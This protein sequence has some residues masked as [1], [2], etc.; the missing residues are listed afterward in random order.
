M[1]ARGASPTELGTATADLSLFDWNLA[2]ECE[3][4]SKLT[5][6]GERNL[7]AVNSSRQATE[8]KYFFALG[9][10]P[11]L[12]IP[13]CPDGLRRQLAS[14]RT[15]LLAR[16]KSNNLGFA[17]QATRLRILR[18]IRESAVPEDC[19]PGGTRV[20]LG[21][22]DILQGNPES[23]NGDDRDRTDNPRLAKAVLSQLSYVPGKS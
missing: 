18:K 13:P 19:L 5:R 22:Q 23:V 6:R 16:S 1:L 10:A 21:D 2:T 4:F 11:L 12:T 17:S 15:A 14:F 8:R 3:V 9:V 20:S 7:T